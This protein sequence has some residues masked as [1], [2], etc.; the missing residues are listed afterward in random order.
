[1]HLR[2]VAEHIGVPVVAFWHELTVIR[3]TKWSRN[4][5]TGRFRL[6]SRE[7][8]SLMLFS[9]N[10]YG[11]NDNFL[12]LWSCSVYKKAMAAT[13]DV[14]LLFYDDCYRARIP[15][16]RNENKHAQ[17]MRR[18]PSLL[19]RI[20]KRERSGAERKSW[21]HVTC[22]TWR[23]AWDTWESHVAFDICSLQVE[24]KLSPS[25]IM[26][27]RLE[28][29]LRCLSARLTL[30]ANFR[31]KKC[32]YDAM[33]IHYFKEMISSLLCTYFVWCSKIFL[34]LFVRL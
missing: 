28:D 7:K 22:S 4:P 21:M 18:G 25:L 9:G 3:V 27:T 19:S 12:R 6:M 31:V 8:S 10:I 15:E 32:F 34:Y 26:L 13:I 23:N 33:N 14:L 20:T 24:R 11:N 30:R 1:M 16:I 29:I 5:A 17:M 2:C